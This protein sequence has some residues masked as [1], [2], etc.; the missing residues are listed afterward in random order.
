MIK[1]NMA[2]LQHNFLHQIS[3]GSKI[4]QVLEQQDIVQSL[5]FDIHS[6]LIPLYSFFMLAEA[7]SI[8]YIKIAPPYIYRPYNNKCQLFCQ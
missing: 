6:I 5:R 4:Q 3:Q 1:L 7:H 2:R 8:K